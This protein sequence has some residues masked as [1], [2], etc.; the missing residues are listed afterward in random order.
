MQ[1]K[2]VVRGCPSTTFIGTLKQVFS[3]RTCRGRRK[4]KYLVC[5]N[6]FRKKLMDGHEIVT[7]QDGGW[8]YYALLEREKDGALRAPSLDFDLR[9]QYCVKGCTLR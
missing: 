8:L 1:S 3:Q 5:I 9:P 7:G 2:Y 4:E 6:T